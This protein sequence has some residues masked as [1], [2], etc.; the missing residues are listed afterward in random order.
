MSAPERTP[1]A[2]A[3]A[4]PGR[5]AAPRPLAGAL[6]NLTAALAPAT[7]LAR[8]QELWPQAVGPA[9]A[10]AARPVAEHDGVVTVA[11][12]AAVWAAELELLGPELIARL[13][14]LLGDAEVREL[15]CRTG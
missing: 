8:V 15:R 11:C 4:D 14:A 6:S 7:Q 1:R 5:R 13:N 10:G 2:E 3:R 12:E 9:I